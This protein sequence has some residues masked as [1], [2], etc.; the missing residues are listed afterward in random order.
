M[1]TTHTCGADCTYRIVLADA[2]NPVIVRWCPR[3]DRAI[4]DTD[5]M[6]PI[7]VDAIPADLLATFYAAYLGGR[8][9]SVRL[10]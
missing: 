7:D 10:M 2:G 3:C 6:G 8:A 9:C 4:D 5:H 1:T